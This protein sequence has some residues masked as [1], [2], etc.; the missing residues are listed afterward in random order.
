VAIWEWGVIERVS[1][2]LHC[3]QIDLQPL[4]RETL[5]AVDAVAGLD[6]ENLP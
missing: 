6:I 3:E 4:G 1:T 2:A 5:A